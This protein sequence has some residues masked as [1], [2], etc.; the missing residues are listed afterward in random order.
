MLWGG[1]VVFVLV[2][3]V[4]EM[5]E[6]PILFVKLGMQKGTFAGI[7]QTQNVSRTQLAGASAHS[8][9]LA[10]MYFHTETIAYNSNL[11]RTFA[12]KPPQPLHS[13]CVFPHK[14][15]GDFPQVEH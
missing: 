9:T 3:I 4:F 2:E 12:D 8:T 10:H 5:Q 1:A 6:Q 7:Q 13:L 14:W 15:L 11:S